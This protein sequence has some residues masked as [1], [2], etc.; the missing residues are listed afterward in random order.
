MSHKFSAKKRPDTAEPNPNPKFLNPNPNWIIQAYGDFQK[1]FR[2]ADGEHLF[3][4]F[5]LYAFAEN[6]FSRAETARDAAIYTV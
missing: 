3:R 4:H 1:A 6:A 2:A 5:R